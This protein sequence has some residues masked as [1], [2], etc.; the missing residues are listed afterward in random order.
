[1]VRETGE[2]EP[3]DALGES[4]PDARR[5]DWAPGGGVAVLGRLAASPL[6][7]NAP[8]RE[9]GRVSATLDASDSERTREREEGAYLPPRAVA[10]ALHPIAALDDVCLETDR[11]RSAVQFEEKATGVAKNRAQIIASPEWGGG[12]GAVLAD[13]LRYRV[14]TRGN[15]TRMLSDGWNAVR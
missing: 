9:K 15:R 13:G 8:W 3:F 11:T 2:L 14:S 6:A 5:R 10:R 12:G 4:L 1:M 7:S